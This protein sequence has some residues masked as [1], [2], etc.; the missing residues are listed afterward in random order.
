MY[1]V[2]MYD[3]EMEIIDGLF[4]IIT[5]SIILSKSHAMYVQPQA[6]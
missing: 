1:S 3:L 5:M 2:A 4:T 6:N